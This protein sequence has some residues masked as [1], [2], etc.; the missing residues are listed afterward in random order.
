MNMDPLNGLNGKTFVTGRTGKTCE[1]LGDLEKPTTFRVLELKV[2]TTTAWLQNIFKE[3][4]IF[5]FRK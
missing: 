5:L 3:N 1:K 2:F 4:E